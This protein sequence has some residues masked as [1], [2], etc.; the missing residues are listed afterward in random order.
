MSAFSLSSLILGLTTI[1]FSVIAYQSDR[2]NEVNRYWFYF[3]IPFATWSLALYFLTSATNITRALEWQYVL[4]LAAVWIPSAYFAFIAKLLRYKKSY[5][6]NA[7]YVISLAF[8]IFSFTH[9]FKEGMI[10]KFDFFWI[11]PGKFYILF[12][13][14]FGAVVL[15]SV[16]HILFALKKIEQGSTYRSQLKNTLIVCLIGFLAGGTNFFP[17]FFN[18][19]PFGN[20]IVILYIIVMVYGVIRY[21]VL[22]TK[23]LAA[24][25]FASA[26]VLVSIV[27]I[28]LATGAKQILYKIV[29]FLIIS[30]FS[31]LFIKSVKTEVRIKDELEK[32][33]V[34]L[35]KKNAELH[36]ISE[37]KTEFVSLASH[38]IR[39]P[40]TSIKGYISLLRDE[41]LGPVTPEA[42][43]ALTIME[44]SCTTLAT[45]V[46]D[47]LDITRIE[48]GRMHYDFANVDVRALL[49]ECMTELQPSFERAK[50]QCI[51]NVPKGDQ[52]T[53]FNVRADRTKLKQVI[54]NLIDNS[55]KYTPHGGVAITVFKKNDGMVRIEIHDT[56]VGIAPEVMPKLFMKFSRAPDASEANIMGTGLGLFIAKVFIEAHEGHVWAE[57]EGVG[58][59]STFIIELKGM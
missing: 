35:T 34:Q 50:I 18:I 56:G 45:V 47:Y 23:V 53:A 6:K 12:P 7:L 42:K 51:D 44:L 15:L 27:E 59:G 9:Y 25:I 31:W 54:M 33:A 32:S 52:G 5:T 8:S 1:L 24:Q 46:N 38:Q 14:F 29:V 20:Y 10:Q 4:D 43:E 11:N 28:I 58:K 2:E 41:D 30:F 36:R 22:S 3:S 26:L 37:E 49:K 40:L 39:G 13:I 55:I 57:S 16:V 17:Q 48:Q 21:K 19:Y